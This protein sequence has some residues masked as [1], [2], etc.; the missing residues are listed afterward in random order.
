MEIISEM[1]TSN[2]FLFATPIVAQNG[3]FI[4]L[5]E[6]NNNETCT[7]TNTSTKHTKHNKM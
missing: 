1:T 6:K 4:S 3:N 5:S 2:K 7:W